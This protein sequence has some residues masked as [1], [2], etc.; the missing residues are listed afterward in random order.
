MLKSVLSL[1]LLCHNF[2]L[3]LTPD[4]LTRAAE[5]YYSRQDYRQSLQ[6]WSEVVRKQPGNS[7]GLV[8]LSELKLMIEGKKPA[9]DFLLSAL[10]S[11]THP[12]DSFSRDLVSKKLTRILSTFVLDEAQSFFLQARPKLNFNDCEGALSLLNQSLS[13]EPEN[14][15]TL[16]EKARCERQ[17]EQWSAFLSTSRSLYGLNPLENGSLDTYLAALLYFG[18]YEQ[19]TSLM[20]L[21]LLETS[22][23]ERKW[24]YALALVETKADAE[25]KILLDS[26]SKETEKGYVLPYFVRGKLL[27]RTS[28]QREEGLK[29]L[30]EFVKLAS[31]ENS[32][33]DPVYKSSERVEEAKKLLLEA[34]AARHSVS[35][36]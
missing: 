17:L 13:L 26:L 31:A 27:L 14:I 9:V 23:R 7:F 11:K 24:I 19:I 6:L 22:S 15:L 16:N 5:Y 4:G 20:N 35:A 18:D 30:N 33:L 36:K 32:K 12:L 2:S 28:L 34:K 3:A 1:F 21:S 25:A 10:Q 8:R 29:D